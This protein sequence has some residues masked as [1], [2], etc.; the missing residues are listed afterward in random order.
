MLQRMLINAKGNFIDRL[1]Q[2][3]SFKSLV[4]QQWATSIIVL[5]AADCDKGVF[6]SEVPLQFTH[7]NA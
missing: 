2:L 7:E 5:K 6:L 1:I 4:A 3:S